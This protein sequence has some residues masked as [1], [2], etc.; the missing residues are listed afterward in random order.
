MSP[1]DTKWNIFSSVSVYIQACVSTESGRKEKRGKMM[2]RPSGVAHAHV[3]H[4][5]LKEDGRKWVFCVG[6]ACVGAHKQPKQGA[7]HASHR[8]LETWMETQSDSGWGHSVFPVIPLSQMKNRMRRLEVLTCPATLVPNPITQEEILYWL[9]IC[10]SSYYNWHKLHGE[11]R[12]GI[13]CRT[14]IFFVRILTAV[15]VGRELTSLLS[16]ITGFASKICAFG[17]IRKSFRD[18]CHHC[19]SPLKHS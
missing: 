3:W 4:M 17:I 2:V 16:L 11:W 6:V 14:L 9:H 18:D 12:E 19:L 1:L 13:W 7:G 5:S 8:E 15:D 10:I